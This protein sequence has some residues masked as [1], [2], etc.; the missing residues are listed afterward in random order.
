[1]DCY[2][3]Q[4]AKECIKKTVCFLKQK[5]MHLKMIIAPVDIV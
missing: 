1:M 2:P 4:R 3:A 5:K